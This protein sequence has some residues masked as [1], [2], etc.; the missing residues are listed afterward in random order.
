M[1]TNKVNIMVY[2]ELFPMGLYQE[3]MGCNQTL[4]FRHTSHTVLFCL[5]KEI[6]L[7]RSIDDF[8]CGAN[9]G[10]YTHWAP[11]VTQCSCDHVKFRS[12][13]FQTKVKQTKIILRQQMC[14]S[15]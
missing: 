9:M 15:G 4:L 13:E 14:K 6:S 11:T 3:D 1:K 12:L 7:P 2:K 10:I 5:T 8:C